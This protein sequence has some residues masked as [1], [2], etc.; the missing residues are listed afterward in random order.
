M[1]NIKLE[2][3]HL[4][5]TIAKIHADDKPISK[6]TF[7]Y[8]DIKLGNIM[9]HLEAE[10]NTD[11]IG[12]FA[13]DFNRWNYATHNYDKIARH[14]SWKIKLYSDDMSEQINCINCG[15]VMTFG[16]GY[17]SSVWHNDTGFGYTVCEDCKNDENEEQAIWNKIGEL[18]DD[19]D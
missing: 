9:E 16:E 3:E 19:E 14:T 8:I 11:K 2:I 7:D 18:I 4:R 6:S 13:R 5:N 1:N 17:T 15:K 12:Y 10:M